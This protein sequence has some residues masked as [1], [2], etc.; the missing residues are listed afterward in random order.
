MDHFLFILNPRTK[1]YSWEA[2]KP[3]CY[4]TWEISPLLNDGGMEFFPE[5]IFWIGISDLNSLPV[6]LLEA[7]DIVQWLL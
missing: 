5:N 7:E 4:F 1:G 6:H 3:F 2:H